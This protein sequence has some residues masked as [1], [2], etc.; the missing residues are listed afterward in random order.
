MINLF[1]W[2]ENPP[3]KNTWV[4]AKYREDEKWQL[5]KT[6]K[7]GCCVHSSFGTMI[8]PVFWYRATEEEGLKEQ[9]TWNKLPQI[10]LYD[11]YN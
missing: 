11:L 1:L 2:T 8:L 10:N 5:L 7:R 6:C 3:P 9:D 4:W